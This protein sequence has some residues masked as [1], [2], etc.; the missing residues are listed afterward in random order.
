MRIYDVALSECS[1]K[2]LFYKDISEI[3]INRK[4]QLPQNF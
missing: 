3:K 2:K 4:K 1:R